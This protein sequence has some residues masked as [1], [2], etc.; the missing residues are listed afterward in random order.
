MLRARPECVKKD[1]PLPESY[2]GYRGK[3]RLAA[4]SIPQ[5]PYLTVSGFADAVSGFA[6]A[7]SG[8]GPAEYRLGGRSG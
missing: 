6:D 8:F 5:G 1:R 2:A 4:C 7:V 3:P